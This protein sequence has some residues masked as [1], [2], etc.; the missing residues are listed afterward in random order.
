MHAECA[1]AELAL[2]Y[3]RRLA[4]ARMEIL[5]AERRAASAA[6]RSATSLPTSRGS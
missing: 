6:A 1:E 4:Q 5:E 3:Y 2:S